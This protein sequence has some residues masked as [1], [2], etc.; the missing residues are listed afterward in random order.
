MRPFHC[1]TLALLSGAALAL[2]AFAESAEAQ[3]ADSDPTPWALAED[4]LVEAAPDTAATIQGAASPST[5]PPSQAPAPELLNLT[6]TGYAWLTSMSG[7]TGVA[8][9]EFDIDESFFDLVGESDHLFGLMGSIDAEYK[10]LVFQLNGVYSHA[11]FSGQ[12]TFARGGGG[13]AVGID[14]DLEID[15]AWFEVFGGYRF[16]DRPLGEA[17]ESDSRLTLD[18]FLGGRFTAM[19]L[20]ADVVAEQMVTLPNGTVL[21]AGVSRSLDQREGW[22]ELFLGGR[23]GLELGEQWLLNLRGDIGGFGIGDSEFSWQ[24]VAALGYRWRLEGWSIDLF[25]GYRAL[26]QDYSRG[27][28]TWDVITHGPVLGAQASLSF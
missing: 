23:I 20:Q 12:R 11:E 9:L 5:F 16:I 1:S 21:Q 4:A 27:G 15:A 14:V 13:A 2:G 18:G 26:G 28:F 7:T 6:F 17:S 3:Q 25:G 24:T 22:A 8:G 10:R 19:E